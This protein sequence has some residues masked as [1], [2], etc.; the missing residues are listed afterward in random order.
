MIPNDA[1]ASYHDVSMIAIASFPN[2]QTGL[3][4][5]QRPFVAAGFDGGELDRH[6]MCFRVDWMLGACCPDQHLRKFWHFDAPFLHSCP[7]NGKLFFQ[8]SP[9]V[10]S[11]VSLAALR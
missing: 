2:I 1:S 8:E 9:S 5:W 7:V 10:S 6:T 4:Q 3:F 11:I